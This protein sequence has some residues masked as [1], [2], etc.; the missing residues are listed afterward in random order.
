[1]PVRGR[2]VVVCLNPAAD[3]GETIL[4]VIPVMFWWSPGGPGGHRG[5]PDG[6]EVVV[7]AIAM[8]VLL[9][10]EYHCLGIYTGMMRLCSVLC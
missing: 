5:G 7:V 2:R 6:P 3:D 4:A 9:L 1:M 8:V 10:Y